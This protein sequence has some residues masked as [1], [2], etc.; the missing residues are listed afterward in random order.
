M[1][2]I[3]RLSCCWAPRLW[4]EVPARLSEAVAWIPVDVTVPNVGKRPRAGIFEARGGRHPSA[5]SGC[6]AEGARHPRVA[7]GVLVPAGETDAN[8]SPGGLNS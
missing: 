1:G 6:G 2:R 3:W 8:C 4:G 5:A 7:W